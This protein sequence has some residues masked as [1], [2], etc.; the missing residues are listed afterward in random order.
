MSKELKHAGPAGLWFQSGEI[1]IQVTQTMTGQDASKELAA[2]MNSRYPIIYLETWEEGRAKEARK[3]TATWFNINAFRPPPLA[4]FGSAGR[5]TLI[6]PGANIADFSVIKL[7]RITERVS[8]QFRSEFFNIFNHP[9]FSLPIV[10]FDS[11]AFGTLN[12]TPDVAAG[13]P[14]LGDGYR[15]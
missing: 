15:G 7:T 1:V 11:P 14:R 4:T 3:Q 12:Q 6:G 10:Q 2:L 8:L 13:N 9:N 5:N